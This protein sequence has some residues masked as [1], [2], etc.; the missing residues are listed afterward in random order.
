MGAF[1]AKVTCPLVPARV[2]QSGD[3]PGRTV[4][5]GEVRAFSLVARETGPRQ[6]AGHSPTTV[7]TGDDMLDLEARTV[8]ALRDVTVFAH[9]AGAAPDETGKS[10]IHAAGLWFDPERRFSS[11]RERDFKIASK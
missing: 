8:E 3:L 10:L 1:P 9:A 11:L 4:N 7:L 2:E 6:V 5:P